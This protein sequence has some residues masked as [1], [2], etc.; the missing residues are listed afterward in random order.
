MI[1]KSKIL[2]VLNKCKYTILRRSINKGYLPDDLKII[3]EDIEGKTISELK[4][5]HK[6]YIGYNYKII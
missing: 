3:S 1:N 5:I 4:K 6:K 2:L